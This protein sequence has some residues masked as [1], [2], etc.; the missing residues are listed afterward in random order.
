MASQS[1]TGSITMIVGPMFSGKTTEL[2]RLI[3]RSKIANKKCLIVKYAKDTRYSSEIMTHDFIEQEVCCRC[4][5]LNDISDKVS[6]YD[7][8][9]IDE[10]SF[11]KNIHIVDNWANRGKIVY[12]AALDS[13]YQR[14]SFIEISK[15][16]S[17]SETIIKLTAIC[18]CGNEAI[19]TDRVS[20]DE[21]L[22]VIGGAEKY[23]S[24][25]R[26]CYTDKSNPHNEL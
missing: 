3:R 17:K 10:G 18:K 13:D 12:I 8:I 1:N 2:I 22:E 24:L 9:A 23:R 21:G 20:E 25:C 6:A 19:F 26:R 5:D 15:L 7:V 11:I 16:M 4:N 14:E